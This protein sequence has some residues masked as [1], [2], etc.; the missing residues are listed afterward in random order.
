M[1]PKF[2]CGKRFKIVSSGLDP[3]LPGYSKGETENRLAPS[4]APVV[5]VLHTNVGGY[6][7]DWACGTVDYY[8]NSGGPTQP[9]ALPDGT[10]QEISL[11]N[12]YIV[13]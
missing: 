9:H 11:V 4:D 5:E 2:F 6:G 7:E 8:V 3:A 12:M 10:A 1:L 13:S